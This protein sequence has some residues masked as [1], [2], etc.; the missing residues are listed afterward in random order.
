M[1]KGQEISLVAT[2]H[3]TAD[4]DRGLVSSLTVEVA[5][6]LHETEGQRLRAVLAVSQQQETRV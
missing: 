2:D 1:V 6:A 3:A 4:A 5:A